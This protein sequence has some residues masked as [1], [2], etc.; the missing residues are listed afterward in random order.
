MA[1]LSVEELRSLLFS[2]PGEPAA[3]IFA[4][5]HA[6]LGVGEASR[7][8]LAVFSATDASET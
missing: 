8:W 7:R 3:G 1:E 2:L 4:A 6:R 5:L